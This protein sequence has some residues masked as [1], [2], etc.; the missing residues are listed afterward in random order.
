MT[1]CSFA[2]QL[3][4][5]F[6][7]EP[8]LAIRLF[9]N[10]EW[11]YK[12][13]FLKVELRCNPYQPAADRVV[14]L[15]LLSE[16][17]A[18]YKNLVNTLSAPLQLSRQKTCCLCVI[19]FSTHDEII[20]SNQAS[21]NIQFISTVKNTFRNGDL[22][23]DEV[24]QESPRMSTE[25]STIMLNGKTETESLITSGLGQK[26]K[27]VLVK[28]ILTARQRCAQENHYVKSGCKKKT[29][30]VRDD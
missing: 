17:P 3:K 7:T 22:H 27:K 30:S 19:I 6:I 29:K 25:K 9:H 24:L 21:P 15:A 16:R 14:I 1:H 2:Q 13:F 4:L 26:L 11:F 12:V 23:V 10:G 18:E 28:K 5:G 20:V 8:Y